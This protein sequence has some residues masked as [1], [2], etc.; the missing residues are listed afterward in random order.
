MIFRDIW[1]QTDKCKKGKE[2]SS[3]VVICTTEVCWMMLEALYNWPSEARC[4]QML[5]RRVKIDAF[6]PI[7]P[8]KAVCRCLC[9]HSS[10]S[11]ISLAMLL[12]FWRGG[13]ETHKVIQL[14]ILAPELF[15]AR[16]YVQK[17]TGSYVQPETELG[18]SASQLTISI[19]PQWMCGNAQRLSCQQAA[20][21]SATPPALQWFRHC[22][23]PD[24]ICC[25]YPHWPG[26]RA[27]DI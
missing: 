24:Q 12:P 3:S 7:P 8:N 2:M 21:S 14:A 26:L 16:E 18:S 27:H 5:T 10:L 4:L 17:T 1:C 22:S 13:T 15:D 6:L 23:P 11:L 9:L 25:L 19:H 20:S